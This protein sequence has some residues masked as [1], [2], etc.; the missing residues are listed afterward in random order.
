M[1]DYE[2]SRN[3]FLKLLAE[4]GEEPAFVARA[5]TAPLAIESL[6]HNCSAKREEMMEWPYR[7]LANLAQCI[8][9]NWQRIAPLFAKPE[10]VAELQA[11]H[12]HMSFKGAAYSS[13]P[14]TKEGS[15]RQYLDSAKRFN[16]AWHAY[17]AGIH[18]ESVNK[19]L[20]DYNQ[21]YPL[22][23]ACAFGNEMLGD[24]FQPLAM[25][26]IAFLECRFPYLPIPQLAAA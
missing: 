4:F 23:T 5:K 12:A 25:I 15:L 17:L 8:G 19:P 10:S 22:E 18:Y 14:A 20:R 1:F 24:G 2:G 21:Y 11:L 16:R 3:E 9:G 6:L 13:W 7:R 26:D